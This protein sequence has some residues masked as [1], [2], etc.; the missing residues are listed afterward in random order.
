M[1]VLILDILVQDYISVEHFNRSLVVDPVECLF[2][3]YI[4]NINTS[5]NISNISGLNI[6]VAS[7]VLDLGLKQTACFRCSYLTSFQL[8]DLQIVRNSLRVR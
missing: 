6:A 8:I 7:L 3:I 2:I 5:V 4:A 1:L